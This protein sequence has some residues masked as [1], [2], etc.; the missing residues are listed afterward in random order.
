MRAISGMLQGYLISAVLVTI[1][2][3]LTTSDVSPLFVA[4]VGGIPGAIIGGVIGVIVFLHLFE[5]PSAYMTIGLI[6]GA[7]SFV[8]VSVVIGF[9]GGEIVDNSETGV[10]VGAVVGTTIGRVVGRVREV[11]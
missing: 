7:I 8:T 5:R 3:L 2:V 4:F 10:V 9:G 6:V 1:I 11:I